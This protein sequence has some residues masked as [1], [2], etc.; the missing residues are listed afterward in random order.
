MNA[1]QPDRFALTKLPD[2]KVVER[3]LEGEKELFEILLRRYNQRLF[4]VIRSYI[5][6]EDDVRDIMQDAYVKSYLKLHQF[7][8][9]SSFSTWLTRIAI[10]E[11]LQHI[12]KNKRLVTNYG[13]T[14]S[15]ENVF[16]LPDTNTMNPEKQTIKTE[17]RA[18]V[19]QAVDRLPEKYRV[20]FVLQQVEGLTNPEIAECLKL[21]DSNVKVR[22]HRAKNLLK[23]ELFKTTHDASIFEFGNH[24]CDAMVEGVMERIQNL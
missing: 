17:T 10:N 19:E 13:K 5:H 18:M 4:R 23:E 11:A 7:N 16:Q 2:S 20:V 22:L 6:S 14:E 8:N 15:L 21:T 3:V 9:Q 24:K 1:I 12:R